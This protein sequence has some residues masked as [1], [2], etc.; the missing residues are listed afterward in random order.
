MRLFVAVLPPPG[1]KAELAR[2]V[3]ELKPLPQPGPAP[4]PLRWTARPGW[5]FTLA[6]LGEVEDERVAPLEAALARTAGET[7]PFPLALRG[8]G[9]F[10]GRALWAGAARDTAALHRLADATADAARQAGAEPDT[11]LPFRPHL[12]LARTRRHV[13]RARAADPDLGPYVA[14]LAPFAGTPWTVDE[15]ALVRSNLPEQGPGHSGPRY[16]TVAAWPLGR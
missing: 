12:T 15:L 13:E 9:H 7:R 2:A 1:A 4:G 11:E 8:S 16:E 3:D 14:A 10:G 5:H 6:F